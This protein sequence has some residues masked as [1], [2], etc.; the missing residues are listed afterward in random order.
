M[1]LGSQCD[2]SPHAARE[3]AFWRTTSI[4]ILFL[5]GAV[6][7]IV[8]SI[9]RGTLEVLTAV[10]LIGS[11]IPIFAARELLRSRGRQRLPT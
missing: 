11:G 3:H 7:L 2:A 6:T 9:V 4:A 10:A 8:T 1:H 5:L